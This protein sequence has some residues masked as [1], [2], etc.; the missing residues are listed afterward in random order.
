MKKKMDLKNFNL[1]QYLKEQQSHSP[2]RPYFLAN[3]DTYE[4]ASVRFPFRTFAYGIGLTYSGPGGLFRVGSTDYQTQ[5]GSLT[6][7]GPGIV[8]QWMGDYQ[9]IHDT[10]FFTEELFKNSLKSSFLKSLP[11]FQSGGMNVIALEEGYI[12]KLNAI[13]DLL[14]QSDGES[15]VIAGLVYSLLALAIK[16]H[17]VQKAKATPSVRERMVSDFKSLLAKFFLEKKDVAFYAHRLHV[18][19]KHLSE[20][21]LEETGKTAKSLINDFIFFEAKSLL[22]QTNMPVKEM[23]HWLGFSDAASFIKAF[24]KREGITPHA[25]RK[26]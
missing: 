7:V 21:L 19:P 17:G 6:T 9:S 15:E 25:Y 2:Q 11:F 14:K 4:K 12:K 5:A 8:C 24:K 13:F 23:C 16:C 22:R 20:V 3:Q 10:V 18:T 1:F 26:L